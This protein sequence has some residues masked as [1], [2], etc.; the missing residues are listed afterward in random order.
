MHLTSWAMWNA[1]RLLAPLGNRWL[2]VQQ[3]ARQAGRISGAVPGEDRDLLVAAAYLHDVGYAPELAVAGFHPL[4]GARW[5]RDQGQDERL[6][7][8]VAHH[9]CATYEA[10]VR[11]FLDVLLAEFEPEES[12]TYDA[13]VFCDMTTG[14]TG[15]RIS[16]NERID[17]IYGRYGPDHEVSRA[18]D[19][20]RSCLEA[21]HNRTVARLAERTPLADIWG[22]TALEV[23]LYAKLY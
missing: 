14:P 12:A 23:M 20:S 2:H 9:S 8:L 7:R 21:C 5:V 22:V 18:L 1:E 10:E 19:S 3:V 15:N 16:F 17:D 11:G 6:A 4:D 13:L